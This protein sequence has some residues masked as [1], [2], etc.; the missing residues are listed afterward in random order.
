MIWICANFSS[1]L[2]RRNST[3]AS[4][5]TGTT[6]MSLSL[7]TI[8]CLYCPC[9]MWALK[10]DLDNELALLHTKL[11]TVKE[12]VASSLAQKSRMQD[13]IHQA[14]VDFER[15]KSAVNRVEACIPSLIQ[16]EETYQASLI[17]GRALISPSPPSPHGARQPTTTQPKPSP[18]GADIGQMK[19]NK[20]N[21]MSLH[22]RSLG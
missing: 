15:S 19:A 18:L 13:D 8:D 20:F 17:Q 6:E 10:A 3:S 11:S 12:A 7:F 9:S 22:R 2:V 5:L 14:Q 21:V 1:A 16:A 4:A